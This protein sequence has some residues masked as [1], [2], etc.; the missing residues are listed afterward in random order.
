MEIISIFEKL[1]NTTYDQAKIN[2]LINTL[3]SQIKYFYQQGD[4][5]QLRQQI[6]GTTYFPDARTVAQL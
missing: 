5:N 3:P 4:A 2:E 1:A 6:A